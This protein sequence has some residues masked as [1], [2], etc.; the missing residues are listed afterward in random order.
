MQKYE[1]T[2]RGKIA[3]AVVL[4][5][6]LLSLAV[7][8]AIRA[9]NGS[10]P[11]ENNGFYTVDPDPDDQSISDGPGQNGDGDSSGTDDP[12]GDGNTGEKAPDDD[13][14]DDP[15]GTSDGSSGNI[16]GN[17]SETEPVSFNQT[18]GTLS[19]SFSPGTQDSLDEN[20]IAKIGDFIASPKNTSGAKIQIEI[21]Q[22]SSA[23]TT[24]IKNAV[25]EAF[26]GQ[27]VA[28]D[29]LAWITYRATTSSSFYSIKFSFIQTS[30]SK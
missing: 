4:V 15:D 6:L 20:V 29:N 17:P 18:A 26:S 24:V 11:F 3:I 10:S 2:E 21:P 19:F 8:L 22:L 23:E 30:S 5:I 14:G 27:G 7:V 9:W 16:S 13:P 12:S 1:L 28:L 25:A